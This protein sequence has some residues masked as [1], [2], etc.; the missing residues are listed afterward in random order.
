MI[1]S[2]EWTHDPQASLDYSVDWSRWLDEIS[3]TILTSTWT[4]PTGLVQASP[5]PSVN[6]AGKI[7]TIWI[8]GGTSGALYIVTNHVATAGGRTDDRSFALRVAAR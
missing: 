5:A 1:V 2:A 3:D 6:V 8:A 4:V 7:T